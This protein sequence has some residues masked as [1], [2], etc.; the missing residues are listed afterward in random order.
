MGTSI[1][2]F[3]TFVCTSQIVAVMFSVTKVAL[4]EACRGW[5]HQESFS[6]AL[7]SLGVTLLSL[8]EAFWRPAIPTHLR[9]QQNTKVAA[10]GLLVLPFPRLESHGWQ[11]CLSLKLVLVPDPFLLQ[12]VRLG[13]LGLSPGMC[14]VLLPS[15]SLHRLQNVVKFLPWRLS[16][17]RPT[18]L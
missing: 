11:F 10:R 16:S 6:A 2:N 12:R 17:L 13:L 15:G 3:L 5:S 1:F 7:P 18:Q 14:R 8:Q 4:G 9:E